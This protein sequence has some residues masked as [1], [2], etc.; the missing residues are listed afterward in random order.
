MKTGW[1]H[2]P[3]IDGYQRGTGGLDESH[4]HHNADVASAPWT[5]LYRRFEAPTS[6]S[7]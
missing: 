5:R 7:A 4:N 2:Q 3:D 6:R 1:H